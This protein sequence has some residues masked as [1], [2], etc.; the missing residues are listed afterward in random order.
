MGDGDLTARQR[1]IME[2]VKR[3]GFATVEELAAMCR[4]SSQTIRRDLAAVCRAGL[5][6]RYH[7]GATVASSVRN[8]GYD[9]RRTIE[10]AAK[11]RIAKLVAEHIPDEASLF[12]G[13][14]TTNEAVATA[15]AEHNGL[16]IVTNNVRA[17]MVLCSNPS[18]RV[19][20]MGGLMRVLDNGVVGQLSD[21]VI[22]RFRADYAVI[23]IS[24]IDRDGT[25][26][27]FDFNEVSIVRHII[28]NSRQVL[29]AA[30]HTKVDR[31]A[32]VELGPMSLVH[33]WFTDREP[34]ADLASALS[35][36]RTRVYLA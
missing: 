13:L 12:L 30:D 25:L 28:R 22:Q 33:A 20:V 27:D 9:V 14:G 18:F 16:R 6:R 15:L 26:L 3:V 8:S 2:Q 17:A 35:E 24:G 31:N 32:F 4:V 29:L 19:V 1:R 11:A 23:G 10:A 36:A 34:P 7:G 5:L 21:A